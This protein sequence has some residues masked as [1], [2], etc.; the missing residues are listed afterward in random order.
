MHF[1]KALPFREFFSPKLSNVATMGGGEHL[2]VCSLAD[3][4]MKRACFGFKI[5]KRESPEWNSRATRAS[6]K[7]TDD[8]LKPQLRLLFIVVSWQQRESKK[9]F[10]ASSVFGVLFCFVFSF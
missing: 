9:I 7:Q 1:L 10:D 4:S 6:Q 5:G 3:G 8:K 2:G